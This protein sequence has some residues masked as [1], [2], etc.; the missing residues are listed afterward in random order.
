MDVCLPGYRVKAAGGTI[1]Q[2]LAFLDTNLAMHNAD[3]Y[4][5]FAIDV[6]LSNWTS[7]PAL[8]YDPSDNNQK[9]LL[10]KFDKIESVSS[11]LSRFEAFSTMTLSA[12]TP[13][14]DF[15]KPPSDLEKELA[16]ACGK[17]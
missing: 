2:A 12:P 7:T 1:S 6:A 11:V 16:T 3:N 15:S 17:E 13:V 5:W 8:H 10:R 9:E 4:A 14:F